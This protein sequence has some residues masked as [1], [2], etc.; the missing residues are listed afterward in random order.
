MGANTNRRRKPAMNTD[1][2]ERTALIV[3][4]PFNEFLS[5]WG[6]M[7]AG[8]GA[9][10]KE[11]HLLSNLKKILETARAVGLQIAYA[12]HH[13]WRPGSFSDKKYLHPSQALLV[14]FK[15]FPRDGFG[16]QYYKGL[17]PQ[18]GEL[19]A[20]E[21]T[22]SSGFAETDLHDQ[23]Q[24]LGITHLIIVGMVTNSCI[25]ATA[26]SAVDLGYHVTLVSDAV[27]AFSPLEHATT[28]TQTYPMIAHRVLTT[29]Q[30]VDALNAN[31]VARGS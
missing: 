31:K 6:K 25:E 8:V 1:E 2:K 14:S 22:C 18:Q 27:A 28:V 17:G 10:V 26:R 21:H 4:D 12:P 24:K 15:A 5:R 23:L 13:R 9:S 30:V 11:V 20:S 29:S 19:V 3:V 7:W 16:G